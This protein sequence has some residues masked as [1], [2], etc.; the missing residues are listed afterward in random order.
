MNNLDLSKIKKVHFIGIGGIGVSAIARMMLLEGKE[1][2]GS[3]RSS[4]GV[5]DELAKLGAKIYFKQEAENISKE[6]ELVIYT[7][8]I[9]EDNPEFAQARDLGLLMIT[10]PQALGIISAEKYTIAVAGTHGKTT[11]TAMLAKIFID[12]DLDPTVVV[13][14]MLLDQ[15]SNFIAGQGKPARTTNG[16]WAGGYFITEACEYKRSF[17]NLNPQAVIITNI[18][19]D[20]LDYYKDL[21]DIQS[22]FISLVEKIPTDGIL[23][24]DKNDLVLAPIL[25]VAKCLVL[26][27]PSSLG[28]QASKLEL[29]QPGEHIQKDALSALTM[30]RALGVSDENSLKSLANFAGTWR[31]FEYKGQAKN[32]ALIY[33]DYAHHPNEITA[34][35]AGARQL[36]ALG[37]KLVV[38]FQPHLFSRTKLL[39]TE[40]S[41]SFTE[42]DLVIIPDIYPSREID[43]GTIKSE[44]LVSLILK[45]GKDAIY[46]ESFAVV[47]EIL[48]A[49]TNSG[50]I[51]ITMGAGDI[52]KVG[53]E[54][55]G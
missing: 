54:F 34:T 36:L 49:K 38:V 47:K 39:L 43:D 19:N 8:A 35:L 51:I 52:Y 37:K 23:V 55:I 16:V 42:A 17:L 12:A 7:I 44:D 13:G 48:Q 6:V 10:Y 41:N 26:D 46:A 28:G 30:A 25:A 1:I 15:H 20:H 45:T 32:G 40:F 53:E 9:T 2:S 27:Y 5:T 22:A 14:S 50:D 33:D 3:D 18:D 29:K 31:R 24:C 11:T 21:A 4:S